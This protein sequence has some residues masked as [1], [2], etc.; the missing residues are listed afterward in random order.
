V[1][2]REMIGNPIAG[3]L[4]IQLL[5]ISSFRSDDAQFFDFVSLARHGCLQGIPDWRLVA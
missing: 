1:E 4:A 5:V 2:I 3:R